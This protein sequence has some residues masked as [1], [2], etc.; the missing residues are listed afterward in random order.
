MAKTTQIEAITR[1]DV[2]AQ[3]QLLPVA[4]SWVQL[5]FDVTNLREIPIHHNFLLIDE[6]RFLRTLEPT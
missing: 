5:Y 1:I 3:S 6:Q 4:G 2:G